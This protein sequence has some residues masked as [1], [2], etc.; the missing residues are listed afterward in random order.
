V[1]VASYSAEAACTAVVV[2]SPVAVRFGSEI[3][4]TLLLAMQQ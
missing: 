4:P 3:T 2:Q 1:F